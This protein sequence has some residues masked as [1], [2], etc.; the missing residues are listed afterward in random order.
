MG[1]L[2]LL[3]QLRALLRLASVE[4]QRTSRRHQRRRCHMLLLFLLLLLSLMSP[5]PLCLQGLLLRVC[6]EVIQG[7]HQGLSIDELFTGDAKQVCEELKRRQTSCWACKRIYENTNELINQE[8]GNAARGSGKT[9]EA[10]ERGFANTYVFAP[11]EAFIQ[12]CLELEKVCEE[13]IRFEFTEEE[14]QVL[15]DSGVRLA[16]VVRN[17]KEIQS[18]F[19]VH[20][21]ALSK[22][23]YDILDVRM[24]NWRDDLSVFK[25]HVKSLED[26]LFN[27]ITAA[28]GGVQTIE[29]DVEVMKTLSNIRT[30]G[31]L[32]RFLDKK[33]LETWSKFHEEIERANVEFEE[34]KKNPLLSPTLG[35]PPR[36]GTALWVNAVADKLRMHWNTM[37]D[38][39]PAMIC[40]EAKEARDSC[41]GLITVMEGYVKKLFEDWVADISMDNP[42]IQKGFGSASSALS[43][44]VLARA[45]GRQY[46]EPMGRQL[47]AALL[48]Q[49]RSHIADGRGILQANKIG[50]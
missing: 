17:I 24:M 32:S 34:V 19:S 45:K 41:F 36:A 27:A 23:K 4:G 2:H 14:F 26:A 40:K 48:A 21:T 22:V 46:F 28:I 13:R 16:G 11:L 1:L 35:H 10:G 9:A 5:P 18:Q 30:S 8:R 43:L 7:C 12:R 6:D 37:Q 49:H 47:A 50:V 31:A 42:G 39:R 33:A 3:R 44:P 29:S 25:R 38:C 15:Q 20:L